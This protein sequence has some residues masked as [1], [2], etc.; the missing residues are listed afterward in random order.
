M[1]FGTQNIFRKLTTRR[2]HCKTKLIRLS[3]TRWSPLVRLNI[4]T[5]GWIPLQYNSLDHLPAHDSCHS[6]RQTNRRWDTN[7]ISNNRHPLKSILV[8]P[9]QVP[10][11]ATSSSTT[12]HKSSQTPTW[13]R[14]S[15]H[16][17]ASSRPKCLSTNKRICPSASDS[18]LTIIPH[19]PR[20]PYKPCMGS[21]SAQRDLKCSWSGPGMLQSR[22]RGQEESEEGFKGSFVAIK[23]E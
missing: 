4:T 5:V 13:R 9:F 3:I 12:C 19:P 8:H 6:G 2:L 7:P 10:K 21:R 17:G 18:S 15:F 16:S 11:G 22:T 14:H 23:K 20:Q 1:N